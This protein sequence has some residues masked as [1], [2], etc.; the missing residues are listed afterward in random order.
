MLASLAGEAFDSP[1][2]RFEVKWDG[3]RCLAF[4]EASTRL[5]S[6]RLNDLTGR[7]P[8][9]SDLHLAVGGQPA[10]L[11][12]EL[13]VLSGGT[14]DFAPLLA[15]HLLRS[16]ARV[17]AAALA[18]PVTYV[19]FDLL[20]W[21]GRNV[22][23]FPLARRQA[24][25][26]ETVRETGN[27]VLSRPVAGEGVAFAAA[28]FAQGLEGVMAKR[29]ES[30]YLP[31]RRTRHWLKVKRPKSLFGVV[32]GFVERVDGGVGSVAV[33]LYD[34]AGG[35]CLAG[36]AGVSLPEAAARALFAKLLALERPEPPVADLEARLPREMRWV[37]LRLV[38][39]LE[40]LEQTSPGH[41]RHAVF[42]E[43]VDRRPEECTTAQLED[44]RQE[45][46]SS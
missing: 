21:R 30:P 18:H 23:A 44:P 43:L 14:P 39:R 1:D 46:G 9:L 24:L 36:Q 29:A 4:L 20:Y 26:T 42:R 13:I 5:Q 34:A 2:F 8:E 27:L 16:H 7:Y 37:E 40:F 32:V 38:C 22:M 6:R 41:L 10:V 3:I 35:L 28:V 25:L 12:G 45:G 11:D 31:G 33:G 17:R 19:A 15:R